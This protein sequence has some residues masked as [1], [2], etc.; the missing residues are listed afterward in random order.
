MKLLALDLS[1]RT[2]WACGEHHAAPR[3]GTLALPKTDE[4]IGRFVAAFDD[5]LGSMLIV[6]APDEVVFEAPLMLGGSRGITNITTT[7]KLMALASHTEFAAYKAGVRC[8]EVNVQKVKK[9]FAGTGAAKKP[10]MVRAAKGYGFAV[11]DDNQADAFGAW[12]LRVHHKYPDQSHRWDLGR[13][14]VAA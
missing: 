5:W 14:G 2:G 8:M 1:S 11:T 10:D 12:C 7:R 13:L 9:F 3:F 4:D 6:E